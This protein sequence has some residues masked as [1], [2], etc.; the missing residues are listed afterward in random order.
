MRGDR[1]GA[2][3]G[4]AAGGITFAGRLSHP[5]VRPTF[6]ERLC[7]ALAAEGAWLDRSPGRPGQVGVGASEGEGEG[8][9]SEPRTRRE[10]AKYDS[11]RG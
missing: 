10:D 8:G 7:P 9:A 6:P 4:S 11:T 1:L 3:R 5:P 2:A